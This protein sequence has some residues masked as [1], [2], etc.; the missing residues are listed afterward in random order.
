MQ[1][2][3]NG[4]HHLARKQM[5]TPQHKVCIRFRAVSVCMRHCLQDDEREYSLEFSGSLMLLFIS[6]STGF[7]PIIFSSLH[8]T[9]WYQDLLFCMTQHIPEYESLIQPC[10]TFV[11]LLI[12]E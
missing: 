5:L 3:L 1:S 9:L 11:I 2:F 10:T 6:S 12:L 4:A 8:C 7:A